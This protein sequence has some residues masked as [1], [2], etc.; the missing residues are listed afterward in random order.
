MKTISLITMIFIVILMTPTSSNA[1]AYQ[2][3]ECYMDYCYVPD[4]GYFF[5]HFG[6]WATPENI[7]EGV[8]KNTL[9]SEK[10]NKSV[11]EADSLLDGSE[12]L[13]IVTKR[14]FQD[15]LK[16]ENINISYSSNA[17]YLLDTKHSVVSK[18]TNKLNQLWR[19]DLSGEMEKSSDIYPLEN[20]DFWLSDPYR[21][22]IIKFDETGQILQKISVPFQPVHITI[23]S[24]KLCVHAGGAIS[25]NGSSFSCFDEN[26]KLQTV[27]EQSEEL[28]NIGLGVSNVD[29][30]LL[31]KSGDTTVLLNNVFFGEVNV[32]NEKNELISSFTIDNE[33]FKSPD[34]TGHNVL[35]NLP[36]D[37]AESLTH[38]IMLSKGLIYI[39]LI[40]YETGD[41]YMD[42]YS[43]DGER[44]IQKLYYLGKQFPHGITPDNTFYS[45]RKDQS[46]NEFLVEYALPEPKN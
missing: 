4:K 37:Y 5:A 30:D 12:Q 25:A 45:I 2:A 10:C 3:E 13:E 23:I 16:S 42:V 9:C 14:K 40:E 19:I 29:I 33:L 28:K 6:R 34:Y 27:I 11:F 7:K 44:Q 32:L 15:S 17:V 35:A 20:G 39:L 24:N 41:R 22:M 46:G 31:A 18:L 1:Q 26:E 38:K 8:Y 21:R 43:V 36:K